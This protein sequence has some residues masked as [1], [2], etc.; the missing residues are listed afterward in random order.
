M[1]ETLF[2]SPHSATLDEARRVRAAMA[3]L[4]P[5]AARAREETLPHDARLTTIYELYALR[6]DAAG[7]AATLA[8][9]SDR[10]WAA[11][12]AYRDVFPAE[13]FAATRP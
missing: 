6:G 10:A 11:E 4:D 13:H 7:M 5:A 12:L 9:I 3:G 2:S 1:I 8:R